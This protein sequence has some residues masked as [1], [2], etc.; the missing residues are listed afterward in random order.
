MCPCS[1]FSRLSDHDY[2]SGLS[3][4]FQASI[5][6]KITMAKKY[7]WIIQ[8]VFLWLWETAQKR[9]DLTPSFLDRKFLLLHDVSI[10]LVQPLFVPNLCSAIS[11]PSVSQ[12]LLAESSAYICSKIYIFFVMQTLQIVSNDALC[13]SI[14]SVHKHGTKLL[15]KLWTLWNIVVCV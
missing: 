5:W 15:T 10:M 3:R 8:I 1:D 2:R 12:P 7:I 6:V 4:L 13:N 9:L 14:Q 11:K